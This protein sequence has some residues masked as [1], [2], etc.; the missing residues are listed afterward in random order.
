MT[1]LCGSAFDRTNVISET[2]RE[3]MAH[4]MPIANEYIIM[5]HWQR[6]QRPHTTLPAFPLVSA[7]EGT[8]PQSR[9]KPTESSLQLVP[10]AI[11]CW[12]VFRTAA[13]SH[14]RPTEFFRQG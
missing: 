8:A 7:G 14:V 5:N 11:H 6:R 10:G 12:K 1:P 2:A 9:S 3:S 13:A 4:R